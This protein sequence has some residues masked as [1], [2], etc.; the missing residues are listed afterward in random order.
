MKKGERGTRPALLTKARKPMT[1]F[2]GTDSDI[3]FTAENPERGRYD[4]CLT[5]D[6]DVAEGYGDDVHE[7]ELDVVADDPETVVEIA[8]EYGL[9]REGPNRIDADSPFFYLLIDDPQV[10]DA[11][12]EEGVTAV[13][14]EDEDWDNAIHTCYRVLEPGH[15]TA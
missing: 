1:L 6:A 4:V 3:D 10:Q 7:V 9:N 11:L 2:H 15:I 14:Y 8:D 13:R 12:V 5:P